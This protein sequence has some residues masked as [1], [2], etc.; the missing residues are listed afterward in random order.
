M[1]CESVGG[2]AV[3]VRSNSLVNEGKTWPWGRTLPCSIYSS[4]LFH[5][6]E[7]VSDRQPFKN[8]CWWMVSIVAILGLPLI[9]AVFEHEHWK[10]E[11]VSNSMRQWVQFQATPRHL[12]SVPLTLS[13]LQK[14]FIIS[15][16][17]ELPRQYLKQYFTDLWWSNKVEQVYRAFLNYKRECWHLLAPGLF[18]QNLQHSIGNIQKLKG[19][20]KKHTLRGTKSIEIR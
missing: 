20:Q 10:G 11:I 4:Y 8:T 1:E 9:L 17:H 2:L 15:N 12:Y 18:W 6:Q 5:T 7:R 13:F 16:G 3:E 19:T 14:V